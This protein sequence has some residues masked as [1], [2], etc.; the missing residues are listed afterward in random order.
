MVTKHRISLFLCALSLLLILFQ[1]Q[2]VTNLVIFF[3]LGVVPG[4]DIRIPSALMLVVYPLLAFVLAHW[5]VRQPHYFGTFLHNDTVA[6]RLA[7]NNIG[8]LQKQSKRHR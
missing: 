6:R 3:V 4:T 2:L 5:A 1:T 8:K 7:R